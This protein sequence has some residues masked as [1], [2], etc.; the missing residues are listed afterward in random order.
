MSGTRTV[1]LVSNRST[2]ANENSEEKQNTEISPDNQN[3]SQEKPAVKRIKVDS[4]SSPLNTTNE[5]ENTDEINQND[6]DL[7]SIVTMSTISDDHDYRRDLNEKR[8][9]ASNTNS[10]VSS[11]DNSKSKSSRSRS[12]SKSKDRHPRRQSSANSHSSSMKN[13][14]TTI[15]SNK[16]SQ[17]YSRSSSISSRTSSNDNR[18]RPQQKQ[19]RNEHRHGQKRSSDLSNR[20]R[21]QYPNQFLGRHEIFN[22]TSYRN[23]LPSMYHQCDMNDIIPPSNLH[24]LQQQ[25]PVRHKRFNYNHQSVADH[26]RF[27]NSHVLPP[28]TPLM[29]FNYPKSPTHHRS[30]SPVSIGDRK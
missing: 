13:S 11:T 18:H 7:K 30:V 17:T 16:K 22:D 15:E 2:I 19:N 28:P 25:Q 10:V 26:P 12:R 23:S 5:V 1:T 8:R 27:A 24:H 20:H 9:T 29:D 6:L 21:Q 14:K 4:T 3:D